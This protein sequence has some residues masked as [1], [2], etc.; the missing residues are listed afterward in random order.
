MCDCLHASVCVCTPSCPVE[1]V[2]LN[3]GHADNRDFS[4]KTLEGHLPACTACLCDAWCCPSA[5]LSG[6]SLM[7]TN[8]NACICVCVCARACTGLRCSLGMT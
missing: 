3:E 1:N 2:N 4:E 5:F 7:R 6:F 8:E